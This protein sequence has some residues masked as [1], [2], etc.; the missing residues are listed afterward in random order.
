M[1]SAI[2]N[3]LSYHRACFTLIT[4]FIKGSVKIKI[5]SKASEMPVL[6]Q[7]DFLQDLNSCPA[8]TADLRGHS[9]EDAKD[10]ELQ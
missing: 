8:P 7:G 2:T 3:S 10:M 4:A 9:N 5:V 6:L 1:P